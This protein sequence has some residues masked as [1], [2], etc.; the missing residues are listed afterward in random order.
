MMDNTVASTMGMSVKGI[1]Y[2]VESLSFHPYLT[3]RQ[4]KT[5]STKKQRE[6]GSIRMSVLRFGNMYYAKLFH[7]IMHIHIYI[8]NIYL[9]ATARDEFE[10]DD[11]KKNKLLRNPCIVHVL[12]FP[13]DMGTLY[14]CG[15]IHVD[16]NR[17]KNALNV[18]ICVLSSML[19]CCYVQW[20]K[21]NG[22][23]YNTCVPKRTHLH[24][25]PIPRSKRI[26][27]VSE[28]LHRKRLMNDRLSLL[29]LSVV[30]FLSSFRCMSRIRRIEK[31]MEITARTLIDQRNAVK[32]TIVPFCYII[33]GFSAAAEWSREEVVHC[34]RYASRFFRE[35]FLD[36]LFSTVQVST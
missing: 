4:S 23:I 34:V 3:I 1:R 25:S 10:P 11:N 21:K 18:I 2:L 14:S 35:D 16:R 27:C 7:K 9:H 15:T 17:T 30:I 6:A 33:A 26:D 20:E 5:S 28:I 19:D 29:L 13:I 32:L 22:K 12:T 31:I 36:S 8:S 24:R